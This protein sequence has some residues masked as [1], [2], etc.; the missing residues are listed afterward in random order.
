[1]SYEHLKWVDRWRIVRHPVTQKFYVAW[2]DKAARQTRRASLGTRDAFEAHEKV[3]KI[4]DAE[5]DDPRDF[6]KRETYQTVRDVLEGHRA[7]VESKPSSDIENVNIDII[8]RS[9]IAD[10]RLSALRL[11]DFDSSSATRPIDN[12]LGGTF[13]HW[14]YAPSGRTE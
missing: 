10:R 11:E 14:C 3:T 8:L 9:S 7:Y 2:Y 13:L 6:L 12:Y 4:R 5:V 1:M